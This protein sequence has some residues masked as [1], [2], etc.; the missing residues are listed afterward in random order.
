LQH[1]LGRAGANALVLALREALAQELGVE[2]DEMGFA[3]GQSRNL[4]GA[5]G[6][7]LFLFDRASGGAGFAISFEHLMRPVIGR[8]EKLLDCHTPG[9]EKACAAC[10]LTSDAP[11]RKDDLDRKAAVEFLRAHLVFPKE[12]GSEDRFNDSAELSL[13]PLDEIDRELRRSAHSTLTVFLP[14][15][16][17]LGALQDWPLAAQFLQWT[18]RGHPVRL[19]VPRIQMEKL[20]SAEK[21]A[22]RDFSLQRNTALVAAEAPVLGNSACVLA[23]VS[24]EEDPFRVWASRESQ[25]RFPGPAWG[26]PISQPVVRGKVSIQHKFTPVDLDELLP[27]PGAQLIQIGSELDCDLGTFGERTSKIIIQLLTKCG[28]WPRAGIAHASYQDPYVSS[29]LVARLLIDTMSEIVSRS[30]IQEGALIVETRSP[31]SNEPRSHAWQI[32]HDWQDPADQKG[33]IEELGR[34]RGLR[35]SVLHKDVPHGRYLSINFRDGSHATIVL[36]QGF[37]AWAPP[38]NVIVRHDF[39]AAI[40]AQAKRLTTINAVLQ[41]RGVG[42]T[43]LVAASN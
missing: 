37:G 17:T 18:L 25:P 10:V 33:V 34:E 30:G 1:R 14:G 9:C 13:A 8:A 12:V 5:L 3:V 20:S 41:R 42:K 4:L 28:S 31:R 43:Y 15:W 29:P 38:R 19:A 39:A 36:D 22:I 24:A 23:M 7:S 35:V 27:P 26:Q 6:V 16:T 2:A 11:D 40:S 32:R 21:L